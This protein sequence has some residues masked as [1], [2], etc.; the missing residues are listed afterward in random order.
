MAQCSSTQKPSIQI[1]QAY[2]ILIRKPTYYLF[3]L[4]VPSFTKR[5]NWI[6]NFHSSVTRIGNFWSSL[7]QIFLQKWPKYYVMVWTIFKNIN[8]MWKLLWLLLGHLLETLWLL[9]I[10]TSGHTAVESNPSS[11]SKRQCLTRMP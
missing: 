6:F 11:P 9:L 10:S 2:F 8:L 3:T 7:Q 4:I 5:N 1:P